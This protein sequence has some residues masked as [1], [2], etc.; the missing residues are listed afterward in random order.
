VPVITVSSYDL[1]TPLQRHLHADDHRF[2]ADVEV[3]EAANCAHSVELTRLFLETPDQKHVAQ[4][5]QLLF[6]REFREG[7]GPV[8]LFLGWFFGDAF[9]EDCHGVSGLGE[10]LV[11]SL[12]QLK[13]P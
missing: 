7:F 9:L 3:A 12:A 11:L 2:L 1:I 5:S 13:P 8:S 4:G 6:S 10:R